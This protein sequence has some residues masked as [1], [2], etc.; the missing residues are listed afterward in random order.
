MK[1]K[2]GTHESQ[3]LRM[4]GKGGTGTKGHPAGD[5][6]ITIHIEKHPRYELKEN[7]LYFNQPLDLY[8]AVLGGKL[9]IEIFSK[10]IKM[11]IP[12]GTDSGKVFRLKGLGMPN[13][14]NPEKR[15]DAFAKMMLTVPKHLSK[16]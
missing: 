16:C 4:K 14:E 11:D 3:V 9:N 5:L 6:L 10:T 13:F 1:I 2:P 7:D 8:T 15:G 12:Q